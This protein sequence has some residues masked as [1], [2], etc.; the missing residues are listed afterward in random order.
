MPLATGGGRQGAL[1]T[2]DVRRR[3]VTEMQ[4]KIDSEVLKMMQLQNQVVDHIQ[5]E[6]NSHGRPNSCLELFNV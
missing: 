1:A 3:T 5:T 2:K 6:H 4:K